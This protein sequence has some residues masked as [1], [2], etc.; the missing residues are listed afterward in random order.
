MIIAP[1]NELNILNI[2]NINILN[3][4]IRACLRQKLHCW[5]T[6][7]S[8]RQIVPVLTAAED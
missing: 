4:P 7:R 8:P 6:G 1:Q 5:G 2:L 3:I